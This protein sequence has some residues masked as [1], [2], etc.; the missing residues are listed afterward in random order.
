[1]EVDG[2]NIFY[3]YLFYMITCKYIDTSYAVEQFCEHSAV[4]TEQV[5]VV[6]ALAPVQGVKLV[7]LGS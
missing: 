3:C 1:M 6:F 4:C 2:I 5:L 7:Y